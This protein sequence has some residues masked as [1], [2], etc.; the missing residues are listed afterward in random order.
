MGVSLITPLVGDQV[1][2]PLKVESFTD[3]NHLKSTEMTQGGSRG[4]QQGSRSFGFLNSV[5]VIHKPSS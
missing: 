1:I 2:T 4:D 3:H 5:N